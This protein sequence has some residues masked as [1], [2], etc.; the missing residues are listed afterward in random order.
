LGGSG[1]SLL[2]GVGLDGVCFLVGTTTNGGSMRVK[3]E[4]I[5]KMRDKSWPRRLASRLRK[6][7]K[8][9]RAEAKRKSLYEAEMKAF[10]ESERFTLI[11]TN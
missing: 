3:P 5:R 11:K 8:A 10:E 2:I 9:I 6:T 1:S 4:Y 7:E